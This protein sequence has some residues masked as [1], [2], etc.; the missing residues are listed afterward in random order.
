MVVAEEVGDP[1]PSLKLAVVDPAEE[2]RHVPT[3]KTVL[4]TVAWMRTR[5]QVGR[6]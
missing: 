4:Y 2:A 3:V 5:W 1:H 6:H